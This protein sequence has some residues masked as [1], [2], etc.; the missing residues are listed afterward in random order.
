[1]IREIA[2][3]ARAAPPAA[4]PPRPADVLLDAFA[5]RLTQ[6]YDAAAPVM[7]R[8]LDMIL[9]LDPGTGLDVGDWLWL[10]GARAGGILALERW[11]AD[12]VYALAARQVQVA[13]DAGALVHLQFALNFLTTPLMLAGELAAAADLLDEERLVADA[14]GNPPVAYTRMMVAAWRGREA[15]AAELIGGAVRDATAGGMGRMINFAD[16]AYAVLYNGLGRYDA[17]RDAAQRAFEGDQVGC[18]PFIMPEL[19]EAAARSGDVP[20]LRTALDWLS[21]QTRV[22]AS[23]WA[24]GIRARI[25]ALL[26]D[27]EAAEDGY[28]ES[29]RRLARTRVRLELARSHLLYGEWLRR[30]GRRADAREQLRTAHEMLDAMGLEAFAERA[31]QELTAT[32]E[33]VRKRSVETVTTLTAQEAVIARLARDG[34]TNAEIGVQLF[35]SARTVEWHL[36]KV[37]TKLGVGSRR[38]L[39]VALA[40]LGQDGQTA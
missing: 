29:I 25:R 21:E 14:T 31:R 40:Q 38:E 9:A 19:A 18:G 30:E 26:G 23:E 3:A 24:L 33:T 16:Q 27:G 2:E 17:A 22:T 4:A 12:A 28:R 39:D 7:T 15:E 10:L 36:R 1:M 34:R 37:F 8:A 6:G 35:L 32:G 20:L 11:D 13:R 5:I